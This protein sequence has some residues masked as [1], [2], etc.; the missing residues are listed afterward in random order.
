MTAHTREN[1]CKVFT[2]AMHGAAWLSE[3]P[4]GGI[5]PGGKT[6][7]HREYVESKQANATRPPPATL[8]EELIQ[9]NTLEPCDK[10]RTIELL[11]IS[12]DEM[13]GLGSCPKLQELTIMHARLRRVPPE[14][15]LVR[16]TLRRLSLATNEIRTIEHLDGMSRLHSLFLQ[17][18]QISSCE[19]LEGC[20]ALQRLWLMTNRITSAA[21]LPASQ[22][23]EL[24]ELWL[25]AN[26]LESLGG[27]PALH[28]LQILSLAG[29]RIR[30]LEQLALLV[31]L[32]CLFDL[33]FEDGY[34]GVAP[35]VDEP[36]YRASALRSLKQL[37]VLDGKVIAERQRSDA[38]EEFLQRSLRFNT[39][40]ERL[41][42]EAASSHAGLD[43]ERQV[44]WPRMASDGH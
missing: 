31:E 8:T 41:K 37:G 13:P 44:R 11:F 9:D 24:R 35:I 30:A 26:P 21:G 36:S 7:S 6:R 19:G 3:M 29:T 18:N 14:L 33:A 43:R 39:E 4:G 23:T 15:Q 40:I 16:G 12:L 38:E 1:Y 28:N 22:L 42:Q 17:D 5:G 10:V 34:Y 25:Q 20:P 32:P 2:E 27:I